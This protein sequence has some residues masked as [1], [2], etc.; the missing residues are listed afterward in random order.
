MGK[1]KDLFYLQRNDRQAILAI[2]FVML[3]GIAFFLMLEKVDS[4]ESSSTSVSQSSSTDSII[5]HA[6]REKPAY[7]RSASGV[8][9]V[10]A[11]DPNTATPEDFERLG[12]EKWQVRSIMKYRSKGGIYREP[13]DFARVYGLTK[14]QFE[15]LLPFIR[16]GEDYQAAS[17]FYG[18]SSFYGDY[19]NRA[20]TNGKNTAA[21]ASASSEQS[22]YSYPHKLRAGERIS[23]NT[24]D[25]TELTRIPGI[26]SYYAKSIVRYR[27]RLGGFV[28][29]SQVLEVKGVPEEVVDFI[30]VD[31]SLLRKMEINKLSIDQ[32]RSHPYLTFYQAKEIFDYCRRKG[33]IKDIGELR[34]LKEF[35]PA[36]IERLKPYLSYE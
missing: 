32:L 24:A 17:K 25:T 31:A 3:V 12:L 23:V 4:L 36:A 5:H 29:P 34:L 9:E 6:T 27:D 20:E 21:K 35:P 13:A 10:F 28:S 33:P 19:G 16:I 26:G 7:A 11:F 8:H 18:R 30:T 22:V 2:M 14:K 1:L 15:T